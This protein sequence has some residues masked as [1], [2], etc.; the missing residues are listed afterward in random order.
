MG[1]PI[2]MTTVRQCT[3]SKIPFLA[4]SVAPA[5]EVEPF[6]NGSVVLVAIPLQLHN[7]GVSA[8]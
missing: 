5:G 7:C 2:G 1:F 6:A 3:D 8:C 4:K